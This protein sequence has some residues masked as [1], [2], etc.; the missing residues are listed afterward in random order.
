MTRPQ[1]IL[2]EQNIFSGKYKKKKKERKKNWRKTK[3]EYD[4][5]HRK[6]RPL[7]KMLETIVF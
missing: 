4:Y 3:K 2:S 1:H 5:A 6:I 7:D